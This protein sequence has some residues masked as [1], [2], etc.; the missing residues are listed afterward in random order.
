M[1]N[2]NPYGS[3]LYTPNSHNLDHQQLPNLQMQNGFI[4]PLGEGKK[5]AKGTKGAKKEGGERKKGTRKAKPQDPLPP[6]QLVDPNQ[7]PNFLQS[8]IPSIQP[9]G[10]QPRVATTVPPY[11]PNPPSHPP[12]KGPSLMSSTNS[13]TQLSTGDQ[14]LLNFLRSAHDP[15]LTIDPSVRIEIGKPSVPSQYSNNNQSN[16]APTQY[17]DMRPNQPIQ[18]QAPRPLLPQLLPSQLLPNQYT[19]VR[20]NKPI[21]IQAQKSTTTNMGAHSST[22]NNVVY[23]TT[24]IGSGGASR[25]IFNSSEQ[26]MKNNDSLKTAVAM[27]NPFADNPITL[28]EGD[29]DGLSKEQVDVIVSVIERKNVF[30]TGP[31]G[32]GKSHTIS[33]LKFLYER[34]HRRVGVTSTT[35]ASAVLIEGKTIHSWS[36][37]GIEH[38]K[39]S[40]LKK[41]MTYKN[42]Y[43]RIKNTSLLV[44][45]E[46]SM[47]GAHILDIIDYVFRMV[48]NNPAPFGGMQMLICGDF[49]QLRPVKSELYAFE[50]ENWDLYVS[51]CH[52]LKYIFRQE[53]E[54]FRKALNEVRSGE[55][56]QSTVDLFAACVGRTFTGDIKPTE[57]YPTNDDVS[58]I[59]EDELW[60]L[61]SVD[62]PIVEHTS[63]DQTLDKN[64]SKKVHPE[65]DLKKWVARM[66][67]ECMAPNVLQLAVGAQVMLIKNI[68]VDAGLA[69][70]SRGVIVGF[71]PANAPKVKFR[72]GMIIQLSTMVWTMRVNET[73]KL[74]RTQYPLRL[75]YAITIHKSQGCSIDLLKVDLGSNIFGE[76]M[77]YTA[78]SRAR[79]LEGLSIISLDWRKLMTNK[80]VKEF[81]SKTFPKILT[82]STPNV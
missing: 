78:L 55:I 75:A 26:F 59:N 24:Y 42:P 82:Y 79:T 21:E 25:T 36:G 49:F 31:A 76:G 56:T 28:R 14:R 29:L 35:G 65:D 44:I 72:N 1:Q 12:S 22:D 15:K 17:T 43:E 16:N 33:R 62:N 32:S 66:N 20:S 73:T 8:L 7:P 54:A 81:Y 2:P 18:V 23:S 61:A 77:M 10:V 13:Q 19:D 40:A 6:P 37:I 58:A 74:R 70:G 64:R 30:L 38:K 34:E 53:N 48:R 4:S 57:L 9:G 63:L 5:K 47:L 52:E 68:N 27:G 50:S 46:I 3:P 41:V 71:G 60:R 67:K 51:A 39:E 11:S 45:D 69:N 80:K